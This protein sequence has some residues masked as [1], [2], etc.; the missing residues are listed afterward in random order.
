MTFFYLLIVFLIQNQQFKLI[1]NLCH[2]LKILPKPL[3]TLKNLLQKKLF[4]LAKQSIKQPLEEV[5]K[6]FF[7]FILIFCFLW[8]NLYNIIIL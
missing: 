6:Y 4:S 1:T 2:K 8:K 3:A 5:E 7:F